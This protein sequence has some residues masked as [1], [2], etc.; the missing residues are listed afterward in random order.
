MKKILLTILILILTS[1][2]IVCANNKA[3]Q[4]IVHIG[5]S[6]E[7]FNEVDINDALVAIQLWT[8]QLLN[9]FK[10]LYR[11]ENKI[12]NTNKEIIDAYNN[13]KVD[14]IS[15]LSITYFELMD[16][17]NLDPLLSSNQTGI[18]GYEYV[19][20][21]RKESEVVSISDIEDKSII[22]TP[23]NFSKVSD[24]WLKSKTNEVK[25]KSSFFSKISRATKPSQAIL[26]VFFKKFD[27][28]LVPYFTFETMAELNPQIKQ[29]LTIVEKSEP[30]LNG[31]V[32]VRKSLENKVKEDFLQFIEK[33]QISTSGKLLTSLFGVIELKPYD[34]IILSKTKKIYDETDK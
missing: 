26:S 30:L 3:D 1:Q 20:L 31:M 2:S 15:L 16:E 29:E 4:K 5:Y 10:D 21:S 33:L 27:A 12:Y 13:K 25:N 32:F 22:L 28:C 11:V 24:L 7:L 19:I 14:I 23:S 34:K 9:E 18:N 17:I 8:D 6:K